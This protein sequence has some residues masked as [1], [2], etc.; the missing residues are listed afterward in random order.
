LSF[1]P[2]RNRRVS[3]PHPSRF[4]PGCSLVEVT[5]AFTTPEILCRGNPRFERHFA[6]PFELQQPAPLAGREPATA[7]RSSSRLHHSANPCGGNQRPRYLSAALP[8]SY[9]NFRRWW[10]SN[11]RLSDS[12][13]ILNLHHAANSSI[14]FLFLLTSLLLYFSPAHT[15]SIPPLRRFFSP[16][17]SAEYFSGR[18]QRSRSLGFEPRTLRPLTI[19]VPVNFT[20]PGKRFSR[21]ILDDERIY[22]GPAAQNL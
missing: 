10:E 22:A 20:I 18:N 3:K 21:Q 15:R 7:V 9:S 19:E 4:A 5:R 11:Q 6:L 14:F 8:L 16:T 12:S 17:K 1:C 2:S 13:S